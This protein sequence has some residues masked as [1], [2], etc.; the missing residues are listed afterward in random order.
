MSQNDVWILQVKNTNQLLGIF[1][2]RDNA[3]SAGALWLETAPCKS[4]FEIK[5]ITLDKFLAHPD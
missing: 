4:S 3:I 1:S 5:A 2:S